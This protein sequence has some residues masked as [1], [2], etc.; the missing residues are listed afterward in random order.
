MSALEILHQEAFDKEIDVVYHPVCKGK[1]SM[2]LSDDGFKGIVIDNGALDS[3]GEEIV[4]LAEELEHLAYG[5]LYSIS[6]DFNTPTHRANRDRTE[7]RA[8]RRVVQR[9]LPAEKILE[10]W[11]NGITTLYEMAEEFSPLPEK[12]ILYAINDYRLYGELPQLWETQ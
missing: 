9:L 6:E 5:D 10:C 11:R 4:L 2:C 3:L 1:K 7:R 12:F 8:R